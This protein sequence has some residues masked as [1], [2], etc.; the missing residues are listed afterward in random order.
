MDNPT[1]PPEIFGLIIEELGQLSYSGSG[2]A[3]LC[4]LSRCVRAF[5]EPCRLHLW[6]TLYLHNGRNGTFHRYQKRLE[7]LSKV[8]RRKDGP[9][10]LVKGLQLMFLCPE[11]N[12]GGKSEGDGGDGQGKEEEEREGNEDEEDDVDLS[13]SNDSNNNGMGDEDGFDGEFEGD[14]WTKTLFDLFPRIFPH[15]SHLESLELK[16]A[17]EDSTMGEVSFHGGAQGI[18]ALLSLMDNSSLK[19][20]IV[21]EFSVPFLFLQHLPACLERLMLDGVKWDREIDQFVAAPQILKKISPQHL[22]LEISPEFSS[23]FFQQPRSL[24][25]KLSTLKANILVESMLNNVHELILPNAL[26]TLEVL[27]LNYPQLDDLSSERFKQRL[28]SS[29]KSLRS[30]PQLKTLVFQLCSD[31]PHKP[32]SCP[33]DASRVVKPYLDSPLFRGITSLELEVVW[34]CGDQPLTDCVVDRSKSELDVLDAIL[35]NEA[36]FPRLRR[37]KVYFRVRSNLWI[38][39]WPDDPEAKEAKEEQ[40]RIAREAGEAFSETRARGVEVI[41]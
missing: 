5:H 34:G 25:E 33:S 36:A 39:G 23:L 16:G 41:F 22:Q 2:R 8:L 19:S 30:A 4:N 13:A 10:P 12:M 29:F 37:L 35:A 31:Q 28:E 27:V 24:Y 7:S 38:P 32:S 6:Q 14:L 3:A 26:S 15:L 11:D 20:F 9:S 18:Q 17:F 21:T 1:F 40:S